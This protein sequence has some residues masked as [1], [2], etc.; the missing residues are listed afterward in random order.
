MVQKNRFFLKHSALLAGLIFGALANANA[1]EYTNIFAFGDSLSDAGVYA[2]LVGP[3]SRFTTN[4]GTV[5]IENLGARYGHPL[6]NAYSASPSGFVL[7]STGNDFAVGGARANA[8]P[9]YLSGPLVPFTVALPPVS[10]QV[11]GFLARGPAD[12]NALYSVWAGANDIFTQMDA[13]GAGGSIPGAFAATASAANDLVA[14]VTRLQSAGVRNLIVVN[15]PDIGTTPF[16]V[17]GSPALSALATGLTTTYNT[18]LAAGLSGK[19]LLYFD[20]FKLIGT[21]L[22]NPTAYGFSNTAI[23][24]CGAEASLGC[25]PG[26]A[27][28]G[29]LFADGV[30]PSSAAHQVISDWVYASLEASSR[31]GV[32]SMVPLSRS[33]AQSRSMDSRMQEFQNFGYKGQGFFVTGDYS[34][35]KND[36]GSN[37]PSVEGHSNNLLLGYEKAF[38]DALFG[39]LTLGYGR[40]PF[41]LGNGLG[42]V[43]YDEWA[44]SAFASHKTGNFYANASARYAWLDF[45]SRRSIVLGPFSTS[46]RGDTSGRQLGAKGQVGYNLGNGKVV[47]GPLAALAWERVN[48]DGFSEKSANVT[49]MSFGDQTRESLRSRLGW[50]I[51]AD[52]TWA[53]VHVRPY[54]QLTYDY[55]HKKDERSYSA[56]FVGSTSAMSVQTANRTGGYGTLLGGINAEVSKTMR[57]GVGA[58]TTLSQAGARNTSIS[59]TLSAPF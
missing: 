45:E 46:E 4:P 24:A 36:A 44:L 30:H 57:L 17:S 43:K 15:I 27:A 56:A 58:S 9:G 52:D 26:A 54:A 38:S 10:T 2:P 50:Q 39:G 28:V 5:W 19:N 22:A 23:P 3:N 20:G 1:N 49:A 32:L 48:I 37:L 33:S 59:L 55:E 16:G 51:A 13:V 11:S 34:S 6:S 12:P 21:L 53:G 7:N 42:T 35:A 31:M 29:A 47:H 18:T 14:Q 41:D 8:M 40:S 25:A